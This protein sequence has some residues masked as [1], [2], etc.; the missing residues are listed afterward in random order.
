MTQPS[1]HGHRKQDIR[2]QQRHPALRLD[3]PRDTS[4][5]DRQRPTQQVCLIGPTS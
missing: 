5:H 2:K 3:A 4:Y 1:C